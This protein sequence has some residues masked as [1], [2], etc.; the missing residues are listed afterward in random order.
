MGNLLGKGGFSDVYLVG[1]LLLS[2]HALPPPVCTLTPSG[3]SVTL[4]SAVVSCSIH[5]L[6]VNAVW[7]HSDSLCQAVD[8]VEWREVAVKVHQLNPQWNEHKRESY[9]KHAVRP[10]HLACIPPITGD[11]IL[12][13]DQPCQG[14]FGMATDC[15]QG[16]CIEI[17]FCTRAEAG[18]WLKGTPLCLDNST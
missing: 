4:R 3:R 9:V 11:F 2:C 13:L 12:H 1:T 14:G 8:L 15:L 5:R 18:L 10:L 7:N 16:H 17:K 6:S